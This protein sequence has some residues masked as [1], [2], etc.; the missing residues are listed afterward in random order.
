MSTLRMQREERAIG[1][2]SQSGGAAEASLPT[3]RPDRGP[4]LARSPG[5]SGMASPSCCGPPGALRSSHPISQQ[6]RSDLSGV[7][8]VS[9]TALRT[10]VEAGRV[11]LSH[12]ADEG[13][14]H[15]RKTREV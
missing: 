12:K 11:R 6:K 15:C 5:P 8:S 14:G 10:L 9:G 7:D 2:Q 1:P 3:Q 13:T 4:R